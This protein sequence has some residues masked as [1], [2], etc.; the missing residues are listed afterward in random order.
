MI[1]VHSRAN[2]S[3][4]DRDK[5]K[6]TE[7]VRAYRSFWTLSAEQRLFIHARCGRRS[8]LRD[9]FQ[10]EH[11]I[12]ISLFA[13]RQGQVHE[14]RVEHEPNALVPSRAFFPFSL[15]PPCTFILLVRGSSSQWQTAITTRININI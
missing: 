11:N 5:R 6:R 3:T 12:Q 9:G 4:H 13:A 2:L 7:L 8:D 10:K 15:H 1:S 14:Y